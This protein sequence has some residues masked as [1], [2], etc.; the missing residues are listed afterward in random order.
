MSLKLSSPS[1]PPSS[2]TRPP[3]TLPQITSPLERAVSSPA[4]KVIVEIFV[5]ARASPVA[6]EFLPASAHKCITKVCA[7]ITGYSKVIAHPNGSGSILQSRLPTSLCNLI[8]QITNKRFDFEPCMVGKPF[9][10]WLL[11]GAVMVYDFTAHETI[12]S[13]NPA[14]SRPRGS[15]RWIASLRRFEIP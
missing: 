8:G 15:M 14:A 5:E 2:S 11:G 9:L 1:K 6:F 7:D 10:Q 3:S 13:S 4:E 12:G